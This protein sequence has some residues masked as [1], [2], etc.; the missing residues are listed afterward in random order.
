MFGFTD[1]LSLL[2]RTL[3]RDEIRVGLG[4]VPMAFSVRH[5]L[6]RA[7]AKHQIFK[8]EAL[9]IPGANRQTIHHIL[10][11]TGVGSDVIRGLSCRPI[12]H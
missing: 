5:D 9:E 11:A 2:D 8:A 7:I 12:T 10:N 6:G 1:L 4:R 3:L